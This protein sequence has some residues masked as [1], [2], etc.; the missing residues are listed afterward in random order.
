MT[1]R[2][3]IV[4]AIPNY[5]MGEQLRTLLPEVLKAGY[6]DVFLLDDNS[7]DGS[8]AITHSISPDI[9]IVSGGENKGAGANR[10]RILTA[11]SQESIV[12]FLD[13]DVVLNTPHMADAIRKVLSK[14][15]FGF[16][17]GLVKTPDGFQSVWNYGPRQSL[18]SG[19]GAGFQGQI[20]ALLSHN[21]DEARNIREQHIQLLSPW[22]DPLSPPI[23]R[24]IYW[25]IE[26]NMIINS[27]VFK[28]MGGFDET[29][30]EHEIQDVAIRMASLGLGRFF[31]PSLSVTQYTVNVREYDRSREARQAESKIAR[32][33]GLLK[34]LFSTSHS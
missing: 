29:L 13:A 27:R 1:S 23:P 14:E 16:I 30:R 3:P 26:S 24:P 17:T 2:L 9:H 15:D 33:H 32:K 25:G 6:D 11:L 34:W 12:H 18:Y 28:A 4:A 7:S 31:E 19:R 22:P 21:P 8:L 20:G 10:N 5:N